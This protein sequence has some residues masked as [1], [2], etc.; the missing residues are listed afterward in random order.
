MEDSSRIVS[1][2]RR[3]DNIIVQPLTALNTSEVKHPPIHSDDEMLR[4][5]SLDAL[6]PG[7]NQYDQLGRPRRN[8]RQTSLPK[9]V[10]HLRDGTVP[11]D[12][13]PFHPYLGEIGGAI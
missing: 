6:G 8:T 10:E 5:S 1:R 12:P 2:T 13:F 3:I 7:K 9:Y 11:V 4:V